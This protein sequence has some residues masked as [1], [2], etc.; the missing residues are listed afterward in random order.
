MFIMTSTWRQSK[1]A[2]VWLDKVEKDSKSVQKEGS[3]DSNQLSH[4]SRSNIMPI[5]VL[6]AEGTEMEVGRASGHRVYSGSQ[7]CQ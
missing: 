5:A 2:L 3:M 1:H 7:M 6:R 4:S